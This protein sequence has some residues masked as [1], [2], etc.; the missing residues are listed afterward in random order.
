VETVQ[1]PFIIG[2]DL[3]TTNSAVAYA[4]AEQSQTRIEIFR[5]PQL[6]GPGEF[7]PLAVLP[8]FLYL[9][10]DYDIDPQA[11]HSPW[12]TADDAFVGAFARDQGASVPARLVSSAKS[13]LCHPN[14]DRKARILPWGTRA[15][16]KKRS[17]VQATAAYL[18]HIKKAWNHGRGDQEEFF[19]ENQNVILT[20][21]ASF[22]EVARELT[23][24]AAQAAGYQSVTLLEEPLAAF[25]SWLSRHEAQWPALV[26]P[27][28]L[29][30]ICDVGG[31]TTDFTLVTLKAAPTGGPRF[32]RI[33]V[34]DH[35]LLGGDNMDLALARRVEMDWGGQGRTL[36][37]DRWKA[38]CHQCRNAKEQI[39]SGA[40]ETW[41]I[42]LAGKGSRLIGG[43][44][45]AELDRQTVEQTVLEGFFPLVDDTIAPAAV[46]RRAIAEFGLPYEP[47]PA[48]S[49]HLIRFL[50][51]HRNSVADALGK[52]APLPDRVLFNGGALGPRIV[53]EKI[54]E[55]LRHWFKP[56][57]AD[58][59]RV[60]ENPVPDLAVG[61][62]AAYYGRVKAGRGVRV[63][64]GSPRAYY[65][66]IA[67]ADG[68]EEAT[69]QAICLV[70]RGLEEGAA[71]ELPECSF[72]VLTNQPV[73][74]DLYSSSFRSGDRSGQLVTIDES[75]TPLPPLQTVIQY[76]KQGLK[77]TIPV[78]I[79]AHY[80]EVGTLSLWCR[81]QMSE[82]RW[83]LQFQLRAS[84]APAGVREETVLEAA[85]V[86]QARTTMVAAFAGS[87]RVHM[88]SLVK[89]IVQIVDLPREQWP[90]SLIRDL[91]DTLLETPQVRQSSPLHEARWMN[92][93]GFCLRP[94]MGHA[95]D[96]Q[97]IQKAWR[98][99]GQGPI[100][101][102]NRQVRCEWWILW[103]RLS[104]GLS[105]GQ[106]R[107]ISQDVTPL[108]NPSKGK[109]TLAPQEQSEIWMVLANLERLSVTDKL[110]WGRTLL[111]LVRPTRSK[112]LH[113]WA[114][115]RLGARE[116]LYGPADRVI[117]P[118]E[119]AA[120]IETLLAQTWGDA[121][122]VGN[123]LAQLARKTGD[124][125][126]DLDAGLIDRVLAWMTSAVA[127][128]EQRRCLTDIMPLDRQAEQV[129]FGESLPAGLVLRDPLPEGT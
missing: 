127:P 125:T 120:W 26:Q 50:E 109:I 62:G 43:A 87:D 105:A 124:R 129:I 85:D 7:G 106:Q 117:P 30:L 118:G 63:G 11:F 83:Q 84:A 58:V 15:E 29:I 92:L 99:Y 20:V 121:K 17:P 128:A 123:A 70:E 2:I 3:G 66:G 64:S 28:E 48:I 54:V 9:P 40:A 49:R 116:L 122:P 76:G 93:T 35:L 22:D 115:A 79:E 57:A 61:L 126:R 47:D 111:P 102:R 59:P 86:A 5:I 72:E 112:T 96:P 31:G 73:R 33:A 65:L 60:L 4:P 44:L 52:P 12:P 95:L 45:T 39:L 34:G 71:I 107:Q 89:Q 18:E 110:Q 113:L 19:L 98:L 53:Q 75:L 101:P 14:V 97:R 23:L 94:G 78:R 81:S 91:A 77:R 10:G 69:R 119:A 36:D 1:K 24:E 90:L 16:L 32:E 108:L 68:A 6:T 104:A 88:E 56:E 21:P 37:A 25:Y 74:F 51:R 8:S 38:L 27:N 55:A 13:W 82:H 114:L 80:S 103:R 100:H 42:A 46:Q 67:R 41:R